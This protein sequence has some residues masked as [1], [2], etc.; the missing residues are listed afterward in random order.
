[1]LALAIFVFVIAV[2][3]IVLSKRWPLFDPFRRLWMHWMP[4]IKSYLRSAPGTYTYLFVLVITTWV[5]Q[6]SS[7]KIAQELLLERSTNL[8]QL[9]RDPMRVLF[10]S[11]FWVSSTGELLFSLLAFSLVAAS[12]ERWIGT[13][14]TASVF[15]FGHVGATLIVAF[16]LWASLNFTIVKSP[17]TSARDVGSSYGLAALA[18]LLT[19]RAPAPRRWFYT[20]AIVLLITTTLVIDPSFSNWGHLFA[21]GIGFFSYF[22]IPRRIRQGKATK[23]FFVL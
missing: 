11:A 7:S 22:F 19:Y 15:F 13:A 8:R 18:A 23:S 17:A 3:R 2:D 9:Y 21:F 6:T 16:W 14:R 20:G 5:L 12:V 1:M 4:R 10:G